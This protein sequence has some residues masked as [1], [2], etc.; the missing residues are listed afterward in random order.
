MKLKKGVP[1]PITVS[2]WQGEKVPVCLGAWPVY[3]GVRAYFSLPGPGKYTIK[4]SQPGKSNLA[5]SIE[6]PQD[7][8]E[9]VMDVTIGE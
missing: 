1:Y 8:P 9:P 7:H 4:W 3:G 5:R 2:V 6:F